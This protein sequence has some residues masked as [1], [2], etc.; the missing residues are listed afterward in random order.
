MKMRVAVVQAGAD[1]VLVKPL[2]GPALLARVRVL[3]K[4]KDYHD[5]ITQHRCA[6]PAADQATSAPGTT[7]EESERNTF[8]RRFLPEPVIA[9]LDN[10]TSLLEPH[11]RDIAVLFVD[12]RGFTS[13]TGSSDPED[14]MKLIRDYHEVVGELV[15]KHAATVGHFAGDG[16]MLF[17]NDPL[18]CP[19]PCG[20]AVRCAIDLVVGMQKMGVDWARLGFEIGIGVG[21]AAGYATLGMLGFE[22]RYD[23]TAIGPVVNLAARL[24]GAARDGKEVLINQRAYAQLHDRVQAEQLDEGLSLRGYADLVPAW[25]V[26]GIS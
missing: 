10:D 14:V 6:T 16:V 18:P 8:L 13:F 25:H 23:Y 21:V 19:D 4:L 17:W 11:R 5:Q 9:A 20:N 26:T 24:S 1:D 15:H 12:L 2:D 3:A 22:G 7:L